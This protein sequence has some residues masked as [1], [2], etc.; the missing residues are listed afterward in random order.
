MITSHLGNDDERTP[1]EELADSYDRI[2]QN[3]QSQILTTILSKKP[4]EFERLV[5]KLLQALGYGGEVKNSGIVTKLSN[6]GGI[7]GIIKEDI[8]LKFRI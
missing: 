6:D 8:L 3:V 4:Q 2:K 5:V 7:D 1:E